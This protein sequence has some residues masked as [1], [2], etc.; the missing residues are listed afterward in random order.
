MMDRYGDEATYN[1]RIIEAFKKREDP[2]ILI[3]VSK[4]LTGSMRREIPCFTWRER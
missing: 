4:L 2:E 3:V 1:S